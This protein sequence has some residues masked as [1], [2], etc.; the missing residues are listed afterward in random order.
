MIFKKKQ[1]QE[2]THLFAFP[3]ITL[4]FFRPPFGFSFVT[5]TWEIRERGEMKWQCR[6]RVKRVSCTPTSHHLF[7][8]TYVYISFLPWPQLTPSLNFAFPLNARW[9]RS[10]A[11]LRLRGGGGA[12][13]VILLT[14][15]WLGVKAGPEFSFS[16]VTN[17]TFLPHLAPSASA[18]EPLS[19]LDPL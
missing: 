14:P 15:H 13:G 2:I 5:P 8:G 6:E 3:H 9:C 1:Q 18:T 4:F 12:L 10:F 7:T 11:W 17:S 19:S 16:L